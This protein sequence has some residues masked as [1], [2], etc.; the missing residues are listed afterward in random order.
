MEVS[1]KVMEVSRKVM[2][3]APAI[4]T[5]RGLLG[6]RGVHKEVGTVQGEQGDGRRGEHGARRGE[7]H[8]ERRARRGESKERRVVGESFE[9][10]VGV[11]RAPSRS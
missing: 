1:R 5:R 9:S 4:A 2:E 6:G 3:A 10:L 8:G 7:A 11:Q